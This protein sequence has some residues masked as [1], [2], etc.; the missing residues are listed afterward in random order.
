MEPP[1]E[2]PVLRSHRQF[3]NKAMS[4]YCCPFLY[5][6]EASRHLHTYFLSDAGRVSTV[7]PSVT[8]VRTRRC[9]ESFYLWQE[10]MYVVQE[11]EKK[12]HF[13]QKPI[14]ASISYFLPTVVCLQTFQCCCLTPLHA[15]TGGCQMD[16]ALRGKCSQ[17][18]MGAC[19]HPLP[20]SLL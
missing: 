12:F 6:Y 20:L 7:T 3:F 1:I 9:R 2:L 8:A 14:I 19:T 13:A 17:R 11:A 5:F 4:S 10:N 16:G 18:Q 15:V